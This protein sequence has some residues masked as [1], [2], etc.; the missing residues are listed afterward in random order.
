MRTKQTARKSTGVKSTKGA[1]RPSKKA[2]GRA[3]KRP[4]N[5]NPAIPIRTDTSPLGTLSTIPQEIRSEI[6]K[7][8][9]LKDDCVL[10]HHYS[11]P[12]R[13]GKTM[14]TARKS[15]YRVPKV[16][17]WGAGDFG[18]LR[19]S[20]TI[21]EE[22]L[23]MLRSQGI[24]SFPNKYTYRTIRSDLLFL[25]HVSNIRLEISLDY[26]DRKWIE[27]GYLFFFT[28]P[29]LLRNTCV[30]AFTD[31]VPEYDAFSRSPLHHAITLLTHFKTLRLEFS[32]SPGRGAEFYEIENQEDDNSSEE[33]GHQQIHFSA[34][35]R[36]DFHAIVL[37]LAGKLGSFLG[38]SHITDVD[39]RD[40]VAFG[41]SDSIITCSV[42]F[43]PH[44]HLTWRR[45]S[46]L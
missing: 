6:F 30:V 26:P 27:A 5:K 24:F 14:M 36:S 22:C 9:I 42:T 8:S 3:K 29:Q 28:G 38:P 37:E 21:R 35:G 34:T 20:K 15:D 18:L 25:E 39:E 2:G 31:C 45:C 46:Q 11:A 13:V 40:I 33:A 12:P 41:Q 32:S 44:K 17:K 19:T 1:P 4:E 7:A 16:L 43:H 10:Q 23:A